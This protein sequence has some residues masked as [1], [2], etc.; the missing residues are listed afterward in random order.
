MRTWINARRWWVGGFLLFWF[1]YF[2]Y[3]WSHAFLTNSNGGLSVTNVNMW[4]DWAAHFTI[5]THSAYNELWPSSSPL[6]IGQPFSY[7]FAADLLSALLLKAGGTLVT[8]FVLPSF[9]FSV[10]LIIALF[11]FYEQLLQS[12]KTALIT[13]TVFLLNGGLGFF[14]FIKDIV[15]SPQPLTTLINPPQEYTDLEP[16]FI[17]WISI[18]QSM[19]IPQRAFTMGF[20]CTLLVL[21]TLLA[22]YRKK[23]VPL[24]QLM[25]T[26]AVFGLLP[27]IHTHSFL[28]V[29]IIAVTWFGFSFFN[30]DK[31]HSALWQWLIVGGITVFLAGI[32]IKLLFISHV[33]SGFMKWFPGWYSHQFPQLNWLWFWFNN[34]GVVP[35]IA[36]GYAVYLI[37]RSNK[38]ERFTTLGLW[39]PFFMLFVLVNLV[40]FQPFIWDN[41]KLLVWVSVGFSALFAQWLSNAWQLLTTK[42]KLKKICGR[43]L[44]SVVFLF[45]IAS[46]G[47][48]AYRVIRLNLHTYEMYTTDDL[49]LAEWVK[50]N[51]PSDSVWLTGDQH[52]NWLYNLTGRQP[53]LAYRGWLW[54]HGYNYRSVEVDQITLF[55]D[56]RHNMQLFEKYSIDYIMI[57]PNE[58]QV[59]HANEAEFSALFP[60]VQQTT[61]Y[62]LFKRP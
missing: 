58:R 23:S 3:F 16:L 18:I 47:V 53:L 34:W 25:L 24:L 55:K 5:G 39:L 14:Y 61:Y 54:T 37:T 59:W 36:I 2:S 6:V 21:M 60:I 26:G 4:G 32:I 41:T 38:K 9:V 52:N 29:T 56:P 44:L 20:P 13:S 40:L 33:G 28:A 35:V 17:R 8:S 57:G 51:T 62:K 19:V 43:V 48:D 50:Q 12:W 22:L 7:P 49:R 45:T 1:L 46:G 11:A 10:L 15:S 31:K 30:P 42:P 27:I